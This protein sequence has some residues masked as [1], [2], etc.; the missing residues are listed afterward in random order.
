MA[1]G[2]RKRTLAARCRRGAGPYL[3]L[4]LNSV[5]SCRVPKLPAH[6]AGSQCRPPSSREQTCKAQYLPAFS[7]AYEAEIFE[8]PAAFSP[9]LPSTITRPTLLIKN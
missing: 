2:F 7:P 4:G 1:Q 9:G 6:R 8:F 3:D 5:F